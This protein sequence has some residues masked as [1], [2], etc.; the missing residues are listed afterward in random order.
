MLL[1]RGQVEC[2]KDRERLQW[3]QAHQPRPENAMNDAICIPVESSPAPILDRS[4]LSPNTMAGYWKLGAPA[5]RVIR[6]V[7]QSFRGWFP[8]S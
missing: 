3:A 6:S 1:M 5:K 8:T 7:P 2:P 4:T